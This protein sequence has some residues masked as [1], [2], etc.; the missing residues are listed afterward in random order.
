M[1][2]VSLTDIFELLYP[3]LIV[4]TGEKQHI[5]LHLRK[6]S[7]GGAL[8][9]IVKRKAFLFMLQAVRIIK[10]FPTFLASGL[11]FMTNFAEIF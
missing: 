7:L 4:Y 5:L 6:K 8:E 2:L 11:F 1:N 10:G 9:I 3:R